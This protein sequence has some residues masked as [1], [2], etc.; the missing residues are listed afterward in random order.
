N[1]LLTVAS[2]FHAFD[3]FFFR[4]VHINDACLCRKSGLHRPH[5]I[6]IQR[7]MNSAVFG[8]GVFH[9]F[10]SQSVDVV[11]VDR[12]LDERLL[13]HFFLCPKVIIDSLFFSRTRGTSGRSHQLGDPS[14]RQFLPDRCFA[15]AAR[16][17]KHKN[18]FLVIQCRSIPS[19]FLFTLPKHPGG[20]QPSFCFFYISPFQPNVSP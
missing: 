7:H 6:L 2:F 3:H 16:T 10:N 5:A 13:F 20:I 19:C 18:A 11:I 4:N 17:D 1:F 14:F 12:L 9:F 15:A 8:K